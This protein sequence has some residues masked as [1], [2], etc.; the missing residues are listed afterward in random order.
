MTHIPL[1]G[2]LNSGPDRW[3]AMIAAIR[4]RAIALTDQVR[5]DVP[6]YDALPASLFVADFVP[7]A[8]L[9]LELFFRYAVD[10]VEPSEHDTLPLIERA[11]KLVRDGMP[12]AEVLT[13]YRVGIGFFWSQLMPAIDAGDHPLIPQLG[14]LLTNYS[15]LVMSRIAIALVDDARQPRWDLLE[16][17][18]IAAALLAGRDPSEWTR[19]HE[20]TLAE[21]FLVAVIR[22]GESAPGT[23]TGLR[24]RIGKVPGAFLHRDRGGWTALVPLGPNDHADPVG[25]LVTRL[26]LR[27]NGS[28]PQFWIGVATAAA[29]ADIPSAYAEA[30]IV[31]ETA[32]CLDFSAVVCRR[33]DMMFEYAIATTGAA[34]PNLAAILDPLDDH[35]LLVGTL[36]QYVANQFNH[37]ATARALYIHRN[38]VTYRLS[39]IA[40][41]TG[42]DPQDP[43]GISTLMAARVARRLV[44]KSFRT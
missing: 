37:N 29:H 12:L 30:Q 27:D 8:R 25:A 36:D 42:Y 31:A 41:F 10:N 17:N 6:P 5:V 33:Q 38:T 40:D 9:N 26:D 16:Q 39:R 44:T 19:D 14:L 23:L 20:V 15:S 34:L 32:R 11:M 18:E 2:E 35:P 28:H 4:A 43:A 21:A 13:N 3:P 7:S 22:L 24:S 1:T